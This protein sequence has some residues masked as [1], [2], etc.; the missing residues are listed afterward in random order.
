MFTFFKTTNTYVIEVDSFVENFWKLTDKKSINEKDLDNLVEEG[1][2][3]K[4]NQE[5]IGRSM[6]SKYDVDF[7]VE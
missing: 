4:V 7:T 3:S 1:K 5:Y 2:A 6:R